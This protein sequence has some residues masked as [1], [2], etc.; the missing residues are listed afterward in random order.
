LAHVVSRIR[1]KASRGDVAAAKRGC[2][3]HDDVQAPAADPGDVNMKYQI[4]PL[5]CR[6]WTLL[7]ITP[8][9]I[10]SHY[11]NNYGGAFTRLNAISEELEALDPATTPAHVI[12]RLKQDEAA[13]LNSLALHELYFASL[14]GDGRAVPELMADAL[15][16]DFGSVDRWRHEFVALANSLDG[17]SG[18][19]LLSWVPRAGRLVNQSISDGSQAVAG[20]I[21]LLALD[22]YEHAYH[23]DFGA[24]AVAYVATFMRNID[25][26]AV[27]GRYED[28]VGVKPPRPLEQKE[29]GDLPSV[30]VDEVKAMLASGTPVQI[31]DT[32]PRHSSSRTAE[33]MEGAVWRDPDRVDEWMSELSKTA[34]V[35]TFCV[36]GF[37]VGCQTATAL[38]K[39]G[40]D[41]RYMAGGHFTWKA[42]KG[43]VKLFESTTPA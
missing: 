32:R 22:M 21:T 39:A 10:E 2:V 17:G 25:W 8:R 35:I 23:L 43:P 4:A 11:E 1:S 27:Q 38:R 29:F 7:G 12:R 42:I 14:G 3:G 15:T 36:Y 16:R 9:L 13:A 40:F 31:I 6:P 41:A 37:H 18:W 28:A 26:R 20:A 5:F 19:V 30:T 34:P 24:N 33:M